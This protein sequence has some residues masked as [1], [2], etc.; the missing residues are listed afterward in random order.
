MKKWGIGMILVS[1]F[2]TACSAKQMQDIEPEYQ[3][4]KTVSTENQG[5]QET[6]KEDTTKEATSEKTTKELIEV[7]FSGIKEN[8]ETPK[9]GSQGVNNRWKEGENYFCFDSETGSIYYVNYGDDNYLYCLKG[10]KKELILDKFVTCINILDNVL[11]FIYAEDPGYNLNEQLSYEGKLYSYDLETKE[12]VCLS[13]KPVRWILAVPDGIYGHSFGFGSEEQKPKI[14]F[15]SFQKKTWELSFLETGRIKALCFYK[16]FY[17]KE[18]WDQNEEYRK[19]VW[20]RKSDGKEIDFLGSNQCPGL[21]GGEFVYGNHFYTR[22]ENPYE[23]PSNE[24]EKL[25]YLCMI[26]LSN[27]KQYHYKTEEDSILKSVLCSVEVNGKLY[28]ANNVAGQIF[29][30]DVYS[31]N[32]QTIQIQGNKHWY[33]RLYTD[34]KRLFGLYERYGSYGMVELLLSGDKIEEVEIGK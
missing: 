26:D 9:L 16:D 15:Y 29:V 25:Y 19:T 22:M 2:F 6:T 3:Q 28:I 33:R 4:T 17:L 32:V 23:N 12:M 21:V 30:G 11:Y 18:I 27:G 1:I 8:G 34:G 13:E 14:Y 31:G 20:C 5:D 10:N 24:E 7:N